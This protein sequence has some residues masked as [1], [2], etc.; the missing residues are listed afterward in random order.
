MFDKLV[1]RGFG[2]VTSSEVLALLSLTPCVICNHIQHLFHL[3]PKTVEYIYQ[4]TLKGICKVPFKKFLEQLD[5]NARSSTFYA[6]LRW[7]NVSQGLH[8]HCFLIPYIGKVK[9]VLQRMQRSTIG[10]K[11]YVSSSSLFLFFSLLPGP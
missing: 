2:S 4:I 6:H 9:S 1:S 10:R 11:K 7:E 8:V 3:A 5:K